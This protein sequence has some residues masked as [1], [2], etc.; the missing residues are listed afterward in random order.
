MRST[1]ARFRTHI[2]RHGIALDRRTQC[3]YD[4]LH[5]FINGDVHP[6]PSGN[7][8]V[9]ARLANTRALSGIEVARLTAAQLA[10][11]P[12]PPWK[13]ISSLRL[14]RRS[15]AKPSVHGIAAQASAIDELVG[16]ARVRLQVFDV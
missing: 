15:H 2:R 5:L 7:R 1:P 16:L 4:D 8:A 9:L 14:M 13:R 6:W 3:L 10:F 11:C 12:Y